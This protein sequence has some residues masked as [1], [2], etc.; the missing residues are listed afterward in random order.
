MKTIIQLLI[1][2]LVVH[3][4][5]RLG[6]ASWR[7]YQFKDAVEQEA[8]FAAK[9]TTAELHTRVV[10]LAEDF[11]IVLES[12]DVAVERRGEETYVTAAYI[13]PIPLVPGVYTREQPFEI[14]VRVRALT[15]DKIR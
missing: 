5:V 14:E 3:G 13:E 11:A 4:C 12:G 2:A 7:N 8:R 10:Q 1:A 15:I 9:L 6:S